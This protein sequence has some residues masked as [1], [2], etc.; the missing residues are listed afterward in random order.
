MLKG[1]AFRC[2][3][4]RLQDQLTYEVSLVIVSVTHAAFLAAQA[5]HSLLQQI[6][7]ISLH[8]K[9]IENSHG[10]VQLLEFTHVVKVASVGLSD[11]GTFAGPHP[12]ILTA[13][14]V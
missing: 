7:T 13:R 4:R 14:S 9:D 1:I 8:L 2:R 6:P 12:K 5:A 3:V 11:K 10:C